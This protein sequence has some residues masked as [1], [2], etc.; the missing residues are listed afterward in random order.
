[1]LKMKKI[2]LT[3]NRGSEGGEGEDENGV[4]IAFKKMPKNLAQNFFLTF[5]S[6][7][8]LALVVGAIVFYFYII[9]MEV[10]GDIDSGIDTTFKFDSETHRKI[11]NEWQ[12]RNERFSEINL[13]QYPDIFKGTGST[14]TQ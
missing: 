14:L 12:L 13:K 9:L 4:F 11:L 3:K 6:L 10:P 2:K 8:L 1:M 5:L 7:L